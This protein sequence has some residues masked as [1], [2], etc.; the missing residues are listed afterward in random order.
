MAHQKTLPKPYA[1]R[2]SGRKLGGTKLNYKGHYFTE[3]QPSRPE[4]Q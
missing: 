3:R 1:G 2:S 4:K